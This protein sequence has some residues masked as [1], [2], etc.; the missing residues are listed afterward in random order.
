MGA[1][2]AEVGEEVLRDGLDLRVDL[3]EADAVAG[4]AVGCDGAD[5]EAYDTDIAWAGG[6]AAGGG[7]AVME[8]EAYAGVVR[9]VGG[10][11]F[12]QRWGEELGSVLDG[13]VD[14]RA[15]GDA[16]RGGDALLDAKGSVE[17]A[18]SDE[19]L[20][21]VAGVEEYEE[22]EEKDAAGE[23]EEALG[24]AFGPGDDEGHDCGEEEGDG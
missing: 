4:C 7:A 17:A 19:G 23:P 20:A 15:H 21:A 6:V 3:V 9:V 13:S 18:D 10:W 11:D 22:S 1:R 12:H 5:S 14:E 8:G 16:L 2:V 24:P